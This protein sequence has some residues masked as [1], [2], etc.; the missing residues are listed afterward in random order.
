MRNLD[1]PKEFMWGAAA[2]SF[3]I[4]GATEEDGRGESIWDRFCKTPGKVFNGDT[5]D[6]ACDH[7]HRYKEDIKLMKEIGLKAYRF[8]IAWPRIFPEGRGSANQKGLDFYKRLVCELL[9][10]GI[11]PVATLYHWDLPQKLQDIGGWDN[12]DVIEYFSQY[13]DTM[14]KNLGDYVK[15]WYTINEPWCIAQVGYGNGEHA[16][17]IKDDATAIRVSHNLI[18]SHAKAVQAYRNCK[19]NDGKIGIVL[20]VIPAYPK[21]NTNEDIEA[22]NI[23]DGYFNRWYLEPCLIGEYP[24]DMLKIYKNAF[25]EPVLKAGDMEL[26]KKNNIDMIGINYYSRAIIK[27]TNEDKV[28]K[29]EGCKPEGSVTDM[30][31]EIYPRGLYDF[32]T[33]LK[34]QYGNPEVYITETGAAFLDKCIIEGTVNDAD[35]IDYLRDHF[36]AAHK[37]MLEGLNLRGCFVWSLMDN[38][39][40][41]FGY[42]KRFG[43]ISIDYETQVRTL[44]R[45]ALWYKD[46]IESSKI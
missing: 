41:G 45:S 8:S 40:W 26:I 31:W 36:E 34:T 6:I 28:L 33:R 17:G 46:V 38:F 9:E 24:Q 25:D 3:Q 20:N 1:F 11:E 5:G 13:S 44:K 19:Y 15:N 37:A 42:S 43:I 12:R 7:F 29:F 14:Y 30:G 35:R 27:H 39:E 4:E 23:F 22:A 18:L 2:A 32:F 21:Q 16:P 10:N